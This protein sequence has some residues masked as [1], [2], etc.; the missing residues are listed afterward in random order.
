ML[1]CVARSPSATWQA[2]GEIE[3]ERQSNARWAAG[4]TAGTATALEE[5]AKE[6]LAGILFKFCS[7]AS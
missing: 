4:A 1:T 2:L 3:A 6:F 5:Q 7:H